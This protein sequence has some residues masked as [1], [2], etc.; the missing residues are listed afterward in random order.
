MPLS[1]MRFVPIIGYIE[2]FLANKSCPGRAKGMFHLNRK[3]LV[4]WQKSVLKHAQV[5]CMHLKA[6]SDE[7]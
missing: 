1:V 6:A 3:F 4:Q 7:N 2:L 5:S